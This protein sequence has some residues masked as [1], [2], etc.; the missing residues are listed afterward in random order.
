MP[1]IGPCQPPRVGFSLGCI[2][3]MYYNKW[4]EVNLGLVGKCKR[5]NIVNGGWWYDGIVRCGMVEEMG[6]CTT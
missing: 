1:A 3:S 5:G 4:H 2:L 6:S